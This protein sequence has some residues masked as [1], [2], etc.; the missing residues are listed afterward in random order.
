M[1]EA[2]Q[3]EPPSIEPAPRRSIVEHVGE[4][5]PMM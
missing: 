3:E 4:K 2:L 1:L 5:M